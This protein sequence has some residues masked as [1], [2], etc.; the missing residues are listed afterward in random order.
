MYIIIVTKNDSNKANR[1]A[2]EDESFVKPEVPGIPEPPV[3]PED[4][5]SQYI[6]NL[7]GKKG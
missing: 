3:K 2:D 6:M 7:K 5:V 1:S 4:K